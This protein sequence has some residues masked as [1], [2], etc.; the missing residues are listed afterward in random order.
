MVRG[1]ADVEELLERAGRGD[2]SACEELLACYRDRLRKMIA[3]RLD[4]RLAARVDP[5]DVVQ[6]ALLTAAQKLSEYLKQRPLPFYPWLR[7]LAWDQL[8]KLHSRHLHTGKR[9]ASREE[10]LSLAL[11]DE[12]AL[13][14]AQQLVAPGTSPSDRLVR[15]ELRG[16][17]QAGLT[18]LPEAHRE[19]LVMRYLEQLSM[20]EIAA[21]L[22]IQEGAV[23][24]RHTRA[25]HRLSA[26]LGGDP[27]EDAS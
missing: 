7:R 1:D 24:M 13:E 16:R 15:D 25:L 2:S 22:G 12:S 27:R 9:S 6:E 20:S 17:V 14:L 5:S 10:P 8:I 21:V 26:L 4:R 11:P 3:V 19:V 23:K 18:R